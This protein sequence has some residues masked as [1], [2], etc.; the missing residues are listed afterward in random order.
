MP[1]FFH[2]HANPESSKLLSVCL[3]IWRKVSVE[4][5]P[6]MEKYEGL[7]SSKFSTEGGHLLLFSY[8]RPSLFLFPPLH[9]SPLRSRGEMKKDERSICTTYAML[10]I[11]KQNEIKPKRRNPTDEKKAEKKVDKLRTTQE[12]QSWRWQKKKKKTNQEPRSLCAIRLCVGVL[13]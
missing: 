11:Q 8:I 13:S 6:V 9:R 12:N 10:S 1:R 3:W 5:K 7:N 2:L 4:R